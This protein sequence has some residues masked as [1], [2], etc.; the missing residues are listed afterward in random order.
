MKILHN[1]NYENEMKALMGIEPVHN[2][3]R[4]DFLLAATFSTKLSMLTTNNF[5]NHT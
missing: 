4:L 5:Q 3:K 1:Q 2:G